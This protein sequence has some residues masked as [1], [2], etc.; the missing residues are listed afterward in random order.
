MR[1]IAVDPATNHPLPPNTDL[2]AAAAKKNNNIRFR[3]FPRIR[4]LDCPGKL[5]N[6][7]PG[8]GV[9]SFEVHLKNR[10]HRE[11]VETRLTRGGETGAGAG[12]E[13]M[14]K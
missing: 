3:Y 5:Y 10:A 14:A 13:G 12:T 4:C 8:M 1:R 6:P 9:E 11:N 7:G 2:A